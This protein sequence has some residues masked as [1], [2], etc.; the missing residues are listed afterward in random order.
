MD[1]QIVKMLAVDFTGLAKD[2]LHIHVGMAVFIMVRM[3]WRGRWGTAIAWL[4]A[5]IAALGGE[6]LDWRTELATQATV[7]SSEHYKDIW[8]TMLWPTVLALLWRWLPLTA[9]QSAQ[10]SGEDRQHGAE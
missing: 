2:A 7:V 5:T 9:R 3:V 4:A 6:W 1:F 8:N 10:M